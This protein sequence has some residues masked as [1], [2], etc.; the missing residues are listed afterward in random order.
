MINVYSL[1][2]LCLR[3]AREVRFDM[4]IN[5]DSN[6]LSRVRSETSSCPTDPFGVIEPQNRPFGNLYA[7]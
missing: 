5:E 3:M 4:Y 7:V 6:W 1:L 2:Q